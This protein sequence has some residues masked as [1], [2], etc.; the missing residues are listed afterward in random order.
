METKK[1][2]VVSRAALF[3]AAVVAPLLVAVA[4]V[5]AGRTNNCTRR[6]G[7]ISI[8]PPFGIED[9]CF[10]D[11]FNLTCDRSHQP[12]KLFLGDGTV[13][14][15]EIS[16][17]DATVRVIGGFTYFPGSVDDYSGI[18]SRVSNPV[19]AG[20]WSGALR[21]AGPYTLAVRRNKL[22]VIGCNVQVLVGEDSSEDL[23]GCSAVCSR[24]RDVNPRR[25]VKDC[26]GATC[27]QSEIMLGRSS[28]RFRILRVNGATGLNSSAFAWIME[29][30]GLLSSHALFDDDYIPLPLPA[31]LNWKINYTVCH[32]NTSSAAC[33][34]SQSY[35][36]NSTGRNTV[37]N[38]HLCYC[39]SGYQ[40]NPYE[41]DGCYDLNECKFPKIYPCYGTCNNTEGG[42][43]CSCP[44]GYEGNA[45][46]PNG[47]K[48]S[49]SPH[50]GNILS[51]W[52]NAKSL[53]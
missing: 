41:P 50:S 39:P 11:G 26:T 25:P 8:P 34:S 7:G 5:A 6:C 53:I 48:R 27:C 24:R 35:C 19:T 17:P 3:T 12:P 21:E 22:V 44:P 51:C 43:Q 10:L 13:E 52:A 36:K 49:Y 30:G 29:S 28:Y 20:I 18:P 45:F 15:L 16:V 33:R 9:G 4:G 37:P 47:C 31:V 46:A 42:Y 1:V 23:G 2:A 14:V 38:A 40:G 32:G